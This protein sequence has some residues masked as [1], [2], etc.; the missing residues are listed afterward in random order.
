[1]E[2]G[3]NYI[4]YCTEC[5]NI[6]EYSNQSDFILAEPFCKDCWIIRQR[7]FELRN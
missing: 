7:E 5:G 2:C 1:M 3:F 6:I 4:D